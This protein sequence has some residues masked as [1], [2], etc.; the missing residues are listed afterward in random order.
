[1]GYGHYADALLQAC[2]FVPGL[3]PV[4]LGRAGH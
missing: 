4:E 2:K 3:K 1:M